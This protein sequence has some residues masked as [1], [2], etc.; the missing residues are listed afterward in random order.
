MLSKFK[1]YLY[2]NIYINIV[3]SSKDTCIYV[4]EI[5]YKGL[6]N[7]YEEIFNTSNKSEIYEYIKTF[8]SRSPINYVSILDP[9]LTQGAA[10]TCSHHEIKKYCTLEEFEQICVDD[11]WS[12]YTSKL[13]LLDIQGRYK[14]QA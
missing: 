14:K 1:T 11:K 6:S 8:I 2:N 7:N 9:S 12:Y 5:D 10:P 13:D 4:E 3:Q